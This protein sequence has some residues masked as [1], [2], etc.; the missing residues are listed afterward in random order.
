MESTSTHSKKCSRYAGYKKHS[1]DPK[2]QK[3]E[4]LARHRTSYSLN[5]H[6]SGVFTFNRRG[7]A[8]NF[9][10]EVSSNTFWQCE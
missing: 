3:A 1:G 2:R 4:V 5:R 6:G 8:S 7:D 9:H 10:S